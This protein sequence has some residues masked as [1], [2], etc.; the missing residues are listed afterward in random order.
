MTLP[1]GTARKLRVNGTSLA[2]PTIASDGRVKSLTINGDRSEIE[3]V[4]SRD[5]RKT[6]FDSAAGKTG[7]VRDATMDS[8]ETWFTTGTGYLT[9]TFGSGYISGNDNTYCMVDT[10]NPINRVVQRFSGPICTIA[11]LTDSTLSDM[12]HVNFNSES[13]VYA[14]FWKTGVGA[15]QQLSLS[16]QAASVPDIDDGVEHEMVLDVLGNWI[17]AY[18]D[19]E[20]VFT[21]YHE[22]I[23]SVCGNWAFAQ[24]HDAAGDR[25]YGIETH[26]FDLAESEGV[27]IS[28][29]GH[30]SAKSILVAQ[31]ALGNPADPYFDP[32]Q[33]CYLFHAETKKV[34]IES[35]GETTVEIASQRSGYSA[36]ARIK[37]AIGTVLELLAGGDAVG[38]IRWQGGDRITFPANT[39]RAD[40][41]VPVQLRSYTVATLPAASIGTGAI[42]YV[43]DETGGAVPA[44]SDGTDWRR[45]TD[46]VVVS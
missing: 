22:D 12:L 45:T 5:L 19:G 33:A 37:S 17:V 4:T 16:I 25:I 23:S 27:P 9:T 42:V 31:L 18:V 3:A 35:G 6:A 30:T 41:S 43:T 28:F 15:D 21:G 20:H 26:R 32:T 36:K 13:N 40:M 34:L 29:L 11:I 39:D 44:F 1:T 10:G 14:S 46:R 7:A 38:R 24:I 2:L 8:G